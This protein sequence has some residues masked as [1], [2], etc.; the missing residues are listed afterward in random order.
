MAIN[1]SK[2]DKEFG[3]S[4]ETVN[5]IKSNSVERVD[6]PFDKYEVRIQKMSLAESKKGDPML[7]VWFSV[8]EGQYRNQYIF[9]NQMLVN[10]YGIHNANEFLRSL[11]SGIDIAWTGSYGRY[12]DLIDSVFEAIRSENLEYALDYS[13]NEKG[14]PVYR[15]REVYDSKGE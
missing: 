5:N 15:I 1:Y 14:Y 12:A 6:V 9:M 4:A 13:Q 2:W 7:S 11:D 8:L 3:V 10:E